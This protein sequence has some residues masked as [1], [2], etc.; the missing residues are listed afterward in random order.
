[1]IT[2]KVPQTVIPAKAKPRAGIQGDN[3]WMPD[4]VRHDKYAS[5][6]CSSMSWAVALAKAGGKNEYQH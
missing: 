1:M 5:I 3:V 6:S 4:Q 2:T